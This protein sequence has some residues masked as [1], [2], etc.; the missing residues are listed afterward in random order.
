M[1]GKVS[2]ITSW[3]KTLESDVKP[4]MTPMAQ[5]IPNRSASAPESLAPMAHPLSRQSRE[6]P[7]AEAHQ[8][9]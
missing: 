1:R 4:S 2:S 7:T 8:L 5:V 6:A 3:A 9:G